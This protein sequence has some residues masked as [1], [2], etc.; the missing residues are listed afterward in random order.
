MLEPFIAPAL[1][2]KYKASGTLDS[3]EWTLVEA[4][5]AD[6]A[7]GGIQQLVDHYATFIVRASFPL[8]TDCI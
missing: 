1:Y 2:D 8:V 3:S 4:M 6:T 5:R 7:G